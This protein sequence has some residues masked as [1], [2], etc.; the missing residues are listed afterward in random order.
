[1]DD[2]LRPHIFSVDGCRSCH[3]SNFELK[4][5][6]QVCGWCG[7][8]WIHARI[9][10]MLCC[11]GVCAVPHVL[12]GCGWAVGGARHHSR[13]SVP[14]TS[15]CALPLGRVTELWCDVCC[16]VADVD[17]QRALLKRYGHWDA[18]FDI[19]TFP[20]NTD[21]IDPSGQNVLIRNVS[22]ECFD[23][24]V[25]VKPCNGGCRYSKC[26]QN[27]TVQDSQITWGLGMTVRRAAPRRAAPPPPQRAVLCCESSAVLRAV[28]VCDCRLGLCRR[29]I[30]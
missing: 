12:A 13:R 19:P 8:V 22:V 16:V 30:R 4:N 17:A 3:F 14:S 5:S 25:A 28:C 23:D 1:M 26:S 6:P 9:C 20:L 10:L 29:M 24:A 21:G 15:T 18:T 2:N 7:V 27:V 11:W